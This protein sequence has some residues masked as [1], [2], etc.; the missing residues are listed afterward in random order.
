[1]PPTPH[2]LAQFVLNHR[3]PA[4]ALDIAKEMLVK[5]AAVGLAGAAQEGGFFRLGRIHLSTRSGGADNASAIPP[6]D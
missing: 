5:A 3:S 6:I 2:P 4:A 1:M